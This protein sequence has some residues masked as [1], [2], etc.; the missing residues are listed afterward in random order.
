MTKNK[1]TTFSS[2][3][4]SKNQFKSWASPVKNDVHSAFCTV[5]KK[6]FNLSNMYE[7][8]LISH[9]NGKKHKREL[10]STQDSVKLKSF[11]PSKTSSM[12]N[13]CK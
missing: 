3:S 10:L 12:S 6:T 9:M 4:L 5:C 8:A 2:D 11:F 7:N 1:K 13:S